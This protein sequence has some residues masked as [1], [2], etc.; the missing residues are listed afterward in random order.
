M[1]MSALSWMMSS[2]KTVWVLAFVIV[3]Q[4]ELNFIGIATDS[5]VLNI[6]QEKEVVYELR[7]LSTKALEGKNDLHWQ[8]LSIH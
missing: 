1:N 5:L 2:L 8:M 3:F 6:G 4:P 7:G